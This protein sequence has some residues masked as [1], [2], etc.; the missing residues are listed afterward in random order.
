MS[1]P[2]VATQLSNPK[3]EQHA[4]TSE[5]VKLEMS[6]APT[7]PNVRGRGRG[8]SA[9]GRGRAGRANQPY[10]REKPATDLKIGT[11]SVSGPGRSL[12]MMYADKATFTLY[13][14]NSGIEFLC[15]TVF[16]AIAA[17]DYRSV[18]NVTVDHLRYV[19]SLCYFYRC[20]RVTDLVGMRLV[21]Y[22]LADLKAACT[23]IRLPAVLCDYIEALGSVQL[24][25]GATVAPWSSTP[26]EWYS[27]PGMWAPGEF[28]T[29]LHLQGRGPWS[30]NY[31]AVIA[32]NNATTRPATRSMGFRTVQFDK[33]EGSQG[34]LVSARL[35]RRDLTEPVCM[36]ILPNQEGQLHACYTWRDYDNMIDWPG[37]TAR[38]TSPIF[39]AQTVSPSQFWGEVVVASF[40]DPTM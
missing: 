16:N 29:R 38:F 11:T 25:T 8:G 28:L 9:R 31:Q 19:T 3:V 6:T 35:I 15:C 32:W 26:H 23:G 27:M 34:I 1:K 17:R 20:I 21:P 14:S 24:S 30:I 22:D 12:L 10:F 7:K 37:D 18:A 4:S 13:C 33:I 2:D 39:K 5:V 40:T 36:Q